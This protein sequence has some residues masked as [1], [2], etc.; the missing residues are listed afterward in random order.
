M[1][2][3]LVTPVVVFLIRPAIDAFAVFGRAAAAANKDVTRSDNTL[4]RYPKIQHH[5]FLLFML[6]PSA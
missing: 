5:F 2:F 1:G 6:S 4:H 3:T